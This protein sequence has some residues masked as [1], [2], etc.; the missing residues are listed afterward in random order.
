M[1]RNYRNALQWCEYLFG[2]SGTYRS[3]QERIIAYF[4]TEVEISSQDKGETISDEE[5][6]RWTS[7]LTD[8]V[9]ILPK[10][11][12]LGLD[13]AC[14]GNA[15]ASLLL[16][17]KRFLSPQDNP[18]VMYAFKEAAS[19]PDKFKL[20]YD[21]S[22][23]RFSGLDPSRDGKSCLFKVIDMPD[24]LERTLKI[25]IWPVQQ[26]EVIHDPWSN[27]CSYIWRIPEEYRREIRRGNMHVLERAPQP[28][29]DAVHKNGW[30]L[31][32]K[33][34]LYHMREPTLSGVRHRGHGISRT[35][36]NFRDIYHTAVLDKQNE[37]ISLDYVTPF[38]VLTPDTR[39]TSGGVGGGAQ[40]DPLMG[41][42]LGM[43]RGA[44]ESMLRARRRDPARWNVLPYPLKYQALGGDAQQFAPTELI[45]Q[46]YDKLLNASKVPPDMYR[47][48]LALQ[49][50]PV[51]LRLFEAIHLPMV[52]ANNQFLKWFATAAVKILKLSAVKLAMQ[53]V[54]HADNFDLKMLMMQL[55]MGQQVSG[56]TALQQ[57]GLKWKDQQRMIAEEAGFTQQIQADVQDEMSQAAI[58]EQIAKGQQAGAAGGAA[59][60]GMG[61][62]GMQQG[63]PQGGGGGGGGAGGGNG[64]LGATPGP[65]SQYLSSGSQSTALNEMEED[66]DSLAQGLAGLPS[67]QQISELRAL[68]QKNPVMHSLVSSKRKDTQSKA[69]SAGAAMLMGQNGQQQ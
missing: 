10:M 29:L 68:K 18:G 40:A 5:K 25:K 37:S 38:R 3:A 35:L 52:T 56:E 32:D 50:A 11:Y 19:N 49:V 64:M 2:C 61:G 23:N 57:L 9:E 42:N 67:S 17:F 8:T 12:A 34:A 46:A 27:E 4:L 45:D 58:G 30:F 21:A 7:L 69:R 33:D 66:A 16:P 48:T 31:F 22:Q 44:T 26:I 28:I 59:G 54:T 60:P 13:C 62:A 15:Y 1:P 39:S 43:F 65:V 6:D 63:M 47:G 51:A 55:Y 14:Y 41:F 53:R 20:Q 36:I 24:D